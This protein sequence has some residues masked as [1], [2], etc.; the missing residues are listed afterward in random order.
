MRSRTSNSSI[1]ETSDLDQAI[2]DLR[3]LPPSVWACI[4][5]HLRGLYTNEANESCESCLLRNLSFAARTCTGWHAGLVPVIYD[6]IYI[7]GE[8][9]IIMKKRLK[10]S[11]GARM[12]LLQRTLLARPDFA[13]L[14]RDLTLPEYD[15]SS[16]QNRQEEHCIAALIRQCPNLERLHG[17]Y[18]PFTGP[19]DS[20][21]HHVLST[22]PNLKEHMWLLS[23]SAPLQ[24][25]ATESF[26]SLHHNWTS[27]ETLVLQGMTPSSGG[28]GLN[29]LLF[30]DLFS[31]L[32]RLRRVMISRFAEYEF[33]SSTLLSLPAGLTHLRLGTLPGVSEA[34]LMGFISSAAASQLQSL[35]LLNISLHSLSTLS[36]LFSALTKLK[37]FTLLQSPD[38]GGSAREILASK[39]L[40]YIHWELFHPGATSVL[41][42]SI[43]HG[44]LPALR[45]L[46]APTDTEGIL[47]A[48]CLPV[49][50]IVHPLDPVLASRVRGLPRARIEAERRRI[51]PPISLPPMPEEGGFDWMGW[52]GSKGLYKRSKTRD[53]LGDP[54]SKVGY[55][56]EPD[57]EGSV[58]AV[59]R[60]GDVVGRFRGGEEGDVGDCEGGLTSTR[61]VSRVGMW[62]HASRPRRRR[63]E[64][65]GLEILFR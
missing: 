16:S 33:N 19:S 55:C 50:K 8:D 43:Q 4:A 23:L 53:G 42:R 56:L 10:V 44:Y 59:C 26:I 7:A 41:A 20:P 25:A 17:I 61:R 18:V 24:Y 3:P 62:W 14:V 12:L 39:S 40:E 27:L 13:A 52:R 29:H 30:T 35:A 36:I 46:R 64:G 65:R 9:S 22:R 57:V 60:A 31:H 48:V 6:R 38:L 58:D 32:P 34:G 37:S 49:A 2:A 51:T 21:L 54:D 28:G 1:S 45:V 47:Q 11:Y 5:E 15:A 63:E